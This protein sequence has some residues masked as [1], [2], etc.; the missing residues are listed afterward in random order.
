MRLG[1]II[2]A[3]VIG[4]QALGLIVLGCGWV[5]NVI[6]IAQHPLEDV[7]GMLVLRC[8]GVIIAPLGC[9]LGFV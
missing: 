5:L 9:V 1:P 8:L 6:R 3:G 2:A 4:I 7:T